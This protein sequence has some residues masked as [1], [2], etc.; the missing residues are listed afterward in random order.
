MAGAEGGDE[1]F[2]AFSA[3][4]QPL[5]AAGGPALLRASFP[6]LR[7]GSGVVTLS[8][9]SED[10]IE[11][12]PLS[13]RVSRRL[14]PSG[15]M[16]SAAGPGLLPAGGGAAAERDGR[17][18]G[19]ERLAAGRR[20]RTVPTAALLPEGG[21]S[22]SPPGS[23]GPAIPSAAPVSER[24]A[25][26]GGPLESGENAEASPPKKKPKYGREEGEAICQA[27]WKRRKDREARK[28][29]Q[30]E[31]RERK[32]NLAKVLRAQRPGECQ[33][34]IAVVL[35][36]VLLQV[37]GGVQIRA[38]LQS[39]N[40]SCVVESQAVPCS[41][42]WRRKS[43]LSQAEDSN[44]WTE[45]PNLLVLLGLEEFLSMVRN[46]K[47][48]AQGCTEQKETLQSFVAR[49]MEKM[50]GKILAL[51][52]VEVEKYFRCLRAQS[53]KRLQQVTANGSQAE[54]RGG[55]RQKRVKDPGLEI[56]RLDV[57]DALV[58]LQLCTRVQVTFFESWEELGEFATMF[59][60]AVAE[61]PFKREQQ[62]TGFSFYLENKW[63]RGMK[64]DPSGKGLLEVWKRQIQ[65]FNRVSGEMAEA[66]VSAY[67][68]PQLLVQA[69][70]RC[71]SEQE[72]QNML[73]ALPV[74]RGT[75]VTA[76][77]RR[78]GPELSRRI[79]VQMTSHDPDLCLD[80]SG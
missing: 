6:P 37:E 34:Y 14:P 25:R 48:E 73:A 19:G 11:I 16:Q 3:L 39:A 55:Q 64:V 38:A 71:S 67:P 40:Y 12:V 57:E 46:Y 2:P 28:R 20:E 66:V 18:H 4:L 9:D 8:S 49:V 50:P 29:R 52:V 41:I 80:V 27:A 60:K 69:Y 36:P 5:P 77:C 59:T 21:P 79:C 32:K 61:A 1:E 54:D 63:C 75:G 47:Q 7:R 26:P 43:V 51:T 22:V 45:E 15:P 53:K 30:E 17:P 35:D 23:G 42:T 65:Q 70:S 72:R 44:E 62:N 58:D 33:K 78:V 10:E 74:R 76:T 68:S 13:E 56:S 31:E 24:T